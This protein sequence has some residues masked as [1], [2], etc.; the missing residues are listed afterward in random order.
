MGMGMGF[1]SIDPQQMGVLE[2]WLGELSGSA[3]SELS[4]RHE[5]LNSPSNGGT[6]K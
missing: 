6:A 5:H 3:P 2:K 4:V 1:T